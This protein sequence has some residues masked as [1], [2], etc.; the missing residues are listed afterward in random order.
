MSIL[1]SF[2]CDETE[3]KSILRRHFMILPSKS[4]KI[5]GLI[6]S[7]ILFV[8]SFLLS[9]VLGST[10]I[11]IS[12]AIDS[13]I[14][15]DEGSNEHIIIQT[16]RT[17]RALIA[18]IV[19]ASLALAGVLM[20]ALT[21]NP[22]A[23]P[24]IFGIN[25]GASFFIVFAITFFSVESLTHLSMISFLGATLAAIAVYFL[26][27]IGRDGLTPIK[28]VL[29]GAAITALFTSATQWLLVLNEK[30]LDEV[31]FWLI[32]SIAGR[33]A[34]VLI[35]VLPYILIAWIGVLFLAHSINIFALGE[36]VA[37]GLGQKTVLVKI[38]TA[39]IIVILAGSSVSIAGPIGFIG[40]IIPHISRLLIGSDY[41]WILPYSALLGAVLLLLADITARFILDPE[42][43]PVGVMTAVIGGPFFIYLAR[44][45]FNKS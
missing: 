20:Q 38:S 32:G 42:E 31:L 28:I 1:C 14:R 36:D 16:T 27:T 33:T 4:L 12:T 41:R 9:I 35:I 24:S 11:S 3:K 34:E 13:F 26:G 44:K 40:L 45:G 25:A 23:S 5:F 17:P 6:F 10:D 8:I 19:G 15:Y 2:F 37:K 21:R 43:V 18:A 29:A 22:L 39:I 30:A 7:L